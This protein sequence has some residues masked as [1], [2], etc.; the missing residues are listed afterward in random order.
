MII[1]G[2][3][4]AKKKILYDW[5][6][7]ESYTFGWGGRGVMPHKRTD[8]T[9]AASASRR[10][11][12]TLRAL[13]ILS[14]MI[15]IGWLYLSRCFTP[16]L[17]FRSTF[18]NQ[19]SWSALCSLCKNEMLFATTR[20][21]VEDS[22]TANAPTDLGSKKLLYVR[23][24]AVPNRSGWDSISFGS[25][26]TFESSSCSFPRRWPRPSANKVLSSPSSGFDVERDVPNNG[27]GVGSIK[28]R[29]PSA[30]PCRREW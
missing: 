28:F 9:C 2:C 3:G 6:I 30:F 17:R 27:L 8:S 13:R 7:S 14:S 11:F 4:Q 22:A 10:I 21:L 18:I 16:S 26:P 5:Q 1:T 15:V 23:I 12:P 20:G 24:A 25:I 29:A 19:R